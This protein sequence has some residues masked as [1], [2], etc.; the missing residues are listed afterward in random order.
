MTQYKILS[1]QTVSPSDRQ[2]TLATIKSRTILPLNCQIA[3]KNDPCVALKS[4][5]G[6][7]GKKAGQKRDVIS[8]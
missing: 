1:N 2:L 5:P 7:R 6:K 4:D 3:L 8:N